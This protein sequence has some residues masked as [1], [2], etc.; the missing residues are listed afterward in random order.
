[1]V[2]EPH[3][4]VTVDGDGTPEEVHERI[5]SRVVAQRSRVDF[6]EKPPCA[7]C[8]KAYFHGGV[9]GY[10]EACLRFPENGVKLRDRRRCVVPGCENHT[11][12][13][14]FIGDFCMPCYLYVAGR[15]QSTDS[16]AY[17]N[18]LK[19]SED[20]LRKAACRLLVSALGL[21]EKVENHS[22]TDQEILN[23]LRPGD[24]DALRIGRDDESG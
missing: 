4:W 13:G 2:A 1:M 6:P 7:H 18:E 21:G 24:L 11:D 22:I 19:R 14:D 17:R 16:Q 20:R 5:W 23:L 3:A 15:T 12:Q 9:N 10:C 8:G